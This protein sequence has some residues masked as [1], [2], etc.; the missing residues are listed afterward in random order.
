MSLLGFG[1]AVYAAL[2]SLTWPVGDDQALF[3]YVSR[4]ILSG[5]V[6]YR[7]AWDIKGP[8]THYTY[9]LATALF[10]RSEVSVRILD[11]VIVMT[12][13]WFMRRLV[14]RINDG[15]NFGANSAVI[16]FALEYYNM[17]FWNTALPDAWGGMLILVVVRLLL[18]PP[19]KLEHT[20]TVV[21]GLL[22]L[23]TLFKPTLMIFLPLVFLSRARKSA[24]ITDR[25]KP[26]L[27]SA[28]SFSLV[29]TISIMGLS[30]LSGGLQDFTDMLRFVLT[31][32]V[33]VER[34]SIIAQLT[35]LPLILFHLGMLLPCLA[36]PIGVWFVYRRLGG[37]Q[38]AIMGI[39]FALAALV[40]ILQGRYW[41]GHWMPAIVSGAPL[42]GLALS[43]L[44]AGPARSKADTLRG[45]IL[46]LLISAYLL[47]P[48]KE[49]DRLDY[50]EW[51][52]Y[53]SGLET[54][55]QYVSHLTE[56]WK[57][58]TMAAISSYIVNR[59]RP[60]DRVLMWGWDIL[61]N[62]LSDRNSPTR[63]AM[64]QPLVATGPMRAKYRELFM[65][66]I[67]TNPP[68]F[69]VVDAQETWF[70]SKQSGLQHLAGFPEFKEFLYSRY[71]L[72]RTQDPFQI[73]EWLGIAR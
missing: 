56:P 16:F 12:S 18:Y 19:W 52:R 40:V 37:R 34:Q 45:A 3:S 24:S 71:R 28:L 10:G 15:D 47:A 49:Q 4:V 25:V 62:F 9:A 11:L 58:T 14:L 70:L 21:G 64:S 22:A 44:R 61:V 55:E 66:D 50:Y 13:C 51:P 53:L 29:I 65:S 57:Y 72:V 67:S 6:A 38:A 46:A 17:G 48:W 39:W 68:K 35:A 26:L 42:L 27:W 31:S 60:D 54:R 7:D 36:A 5:G 8:L 43:C 63:F 23:A 32:Y 2:G 30:V 73:W 69:I 33:P 1:I 59:S 41:P 20:T